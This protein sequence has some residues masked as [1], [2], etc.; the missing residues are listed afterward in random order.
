MQFLGR[1]AGM[2]A[3]AAPRIVRGIGEA[4]KFS[5]AIGQGA[6]QVRNIGTA[7]N[8][9][10]GNKLQNNPLFNKA[11]GVTERVENVSNQVADGASK[12]G[13]ELKNMGY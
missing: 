1:L 9:A 6:R 2:A 5:R 8:S 11:L 4:S 13:T 3:K 7:L 10:T 12:F